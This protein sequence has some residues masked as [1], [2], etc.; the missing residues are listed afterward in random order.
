MKQFTEKLNDEC[1]S[2]DFILLIK[3]EDAFHQAI[4]DMWEHDMIINKS[5]YKYNK[6]IFFMDMYQSYFNIIV[7]DIEDIRRTNDER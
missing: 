5:Y 6:D 3:N 7:V 4:D 1:D 2:E